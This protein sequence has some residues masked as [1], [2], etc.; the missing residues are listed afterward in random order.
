MRYYKIMKDGKLWLLGT[1]SGGEEITPEE[2][3]TLLEELRST[4]VVIPTET[5]TEKTETTEEE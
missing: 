4:P 3:E 1:G 2:Y 5:E